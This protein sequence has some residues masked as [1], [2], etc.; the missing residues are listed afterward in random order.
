MN[1]LHHQDA[2]RELVHDVNR[3]GL[4][5]LINSIKEQA[6]KLL[7]SSQREEQILRQLDGLLDQAALEDDVD[8]TR[9]RLSGMLRYLLEDG[10]YHVGEPVQLHHLISEGVLLPDTALIDLGAGPGE[11]VTEWARQGNPA[12]GIDASPSFVAAS[13]LLRLGLIDADLQTLSTLA[14]YMSSNR[15]VMSSLTLDRVAMPKQLARNLIDLAGKA[16]HFMLASLFPVLPKDD[17]DVQH[18][19]TYTPP[20]HRIATAGT[21]EGDL[22]A[23]VEFLEDYSRRKIKTKPLPYKTTT[24]TGV[25]VYDDSNPLKY[26]V[27]WTS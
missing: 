7:G 1:A 27:L 25:Q 18:P 21:E 22:A 24:H 11:V 13:E 3:R 12:L 17:E 6:R 9:A 8:V 5:P 2:I 14:S 19:I 23:V 26:H 10:D 4:E 15:L 20:N 16:G